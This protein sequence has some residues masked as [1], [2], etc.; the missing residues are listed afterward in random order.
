MTNTSV[1]AFTE[2]VRGPLFFFSA[3]SRSSNSMFSRSMSVIRVLHLLWS[4][5]I[6]IKTLNEYVNLIEYKESNV[7]T[8]FDSSP[9]PCG[10]WETSRIG[11]GESC[12]C[13]DVAHRKRSP[14][15]NPACAACRWESDLLPLCS[16]FPCWCHRRFWAGGKVPYTDQSRKQGKY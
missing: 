11:T 4:S 8:K 9:W 12:V 10:T 7:K 6:H 13:T 1:N 5:C 3:F 2:D 14:C 15:R 16:S